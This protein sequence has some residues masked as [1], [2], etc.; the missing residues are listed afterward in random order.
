MSTALKRRIAALLVALFVLSVPAWCCD[1]TTKPSVVESFNTHDVVARIVITKLEERDVSVTE[2]DKRV[3]VTRYIAEMV[4]AY[5]GAFADTIAIE[6]ESFIGD[7]SFPFS[8][9]KEYLVYL[10]QRPYFQFSSE[11][12]FIPFAYSVSRCSRS[13]LFEAVKADIPEIRR[14]MLKR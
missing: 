14:L 4:R 8:A 3:F 11:F 13:E 5:K 9:E 2:N 10:E 6:S 12:E 1:C 7:C